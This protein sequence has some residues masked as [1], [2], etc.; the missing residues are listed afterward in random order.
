[1]AIDG[2]TTPE[3]KVPPRKKDMVTREEA[4]Q[5]VKR[6]LWLGLGLYA[7]YWL[8]PKE[9]YPAELRNANFVVPEVTYSLED[10]G[11]GSNETWIEVVSWSPRAFVVHN[12]ITDEEASHIME[13]GT[14]T[15]ER[16]QVVDRK[17]GE[18]KDSKVRTSSGTFL[19][20]YGTRELANLQERSALLLGYPVFNGEPTQVLRYS[21]TE[22][23]RPHYDWLSYLEPGET[24][25]AVT[26]LSYL[27]EVEAGGETNFPYGKLH[28]DFAEA[29][30]AEGRATAPLFSETKCVSVSASVRPKKNSALVFWDLDPA[31]V[32]KEVAALHEG[33]PVISGE[34][35]STTI[36]SRTQPIYV[37]RESMQ[38]YQQKMQEFLPESVSLGDHVVNWGFTRLKWFQWRPKR[39]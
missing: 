23:Y 11:E 5:R 1:M 8:L 9:T 36:W 37:T 21:P 25:R 38:N 33:C 32:Y 31:C 14:K 29:Q 27:S 12:W 39:Y 16:S 30:R 2:L 35:W 18:F 7:V 10:P 28:R 4:R 34:K 3:R 17:T 20:R 24:Q 6:L 15:L 13:E 22:Q 26:I 19:P